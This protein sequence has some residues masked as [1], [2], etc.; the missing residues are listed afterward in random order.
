MILSIGSSR[1]SSDSHVVSMKLVTILMILCRLAHCNNSNFFFLLVALYFYSTSAQVGAI[2]L[3]NQ[4]GLTVLYNVFLYK[5]KAIASDIAFWIKQQASNLKHVG[6][7]DNFEYYEN[8]HREQIRD[9]KK[10]KSITMILWV[11]HS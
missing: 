8:V 3:L 4:I 6:T 2:M 1:Q 9:L 11:K 5:L 10:F 7:W